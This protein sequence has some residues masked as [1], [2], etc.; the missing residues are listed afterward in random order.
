MNYIL[1]A[2]NYHTAVVPVILLFKLHSSKFIVS[3]WFL[4]AA[5]GNP[6]LLFLCDLVYTVNAHP[7]LSSLV[8]GIGLASD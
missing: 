8:L 6:W 3:A 7:L 4:L 1:L 5:H 2:I